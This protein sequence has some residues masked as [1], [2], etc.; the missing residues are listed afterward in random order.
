MAKHG[1]DALDISL[2]ALY[3]H[4]AKDD[5]FC[6]VRY[7]VKDSHNT[8]EPWEE[9]NKF[10]YEWEVAFLGLGLGHK[11]LLPL[12]L[13]CNCTFMSFSP[14]IISH[15][16]MTPSTYGKPASTGYIAS[17]GLACPARSFIFVT[18]SFTL[19]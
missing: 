2:S 8:D 15:L 16:I 9:Y 5:T 11:F 19:T 13:V 4:P 12:K 6:F 18:T 3:Q 14:I 1:Q 7:F 17:K 10:L